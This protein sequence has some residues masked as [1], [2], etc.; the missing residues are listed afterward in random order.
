MSS[1]NSSESMIAERRL[2]PIYDL[3]D[4]NN[5][6]KAIQ[7]A[8]RVLKKSPDLDCA[9][10]LK[11][12]A[13]LRLGR[14]ADAEQLLETVAKRAPCDDPTL[15][16]MTICYRELRLPDKICNIYEEAVKK[17][18]TNEELLTH[19][20]MSYVRVYNYK[21]Q[22]HTAMSLYKLKSKN[23]YYFWAVMS[24]VMQAS[25]T[26]DNISKSITLPLA[27]RMVKKFID[28]NRID[29]EQEVQLYV[30]I[31][32]MQ[33]KYQEV[34]DLL[35]SPLGNM[36]QS[37]YTASQKKIDTLI[38][39]K[40]WDQVNLYLKQEL[41]VSDSWHNYVNYLTSVFRLVSTG[42]ANV[43]NDITNSANVPNDTTSSANLP[44]DDS[45]NVPNDVI[46]SADLSFE[47]CAQYLS[48]LEEKKVALSHKSR[49]VHL[50]RLEFY[51][52]LREHEKEIA[53]NT[54]STRSLPL[55]DSVLGASLVDLLLSYYKIFGHTPCC[56]KDLQKYLAHLSPEE[57]NVFSDALWKMNNIEGKEE[58]VPTDRKSMLQFISCLQFNSLTVEAKISLI[59][60]L[61]QTYYLCDA[62]T[63]DQA[64]AEI[65]A[66]DA[67]ILL[68]IYLLHDLYVLDSKYIHY[69]L[70][71]VHYVS[72]R[73]HYNFNLE[74]LALHYYHRIGECIVCVGL[75][76]YWISTTFSCTST[77]NHYNFNLELLALHY[78]H[79]L[80]Y[81]L[82]PLCVH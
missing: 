30:I 24:I 7:E 10:V 9:K 11:S 68:V 67:I 78:Y 61:T 52:K 3:L 1:K 13:L 29:A 51:V 75:Y 26:E 54:D 73:N 56:L 35:A 15:Q 82:H 55:A 79:P 4:F 66:N 16:A 37:Y 18:P 59:I 40:Q 42:S 36:L 25:K 27:E 12:L 57:V 71:Y 76:L 2:R 34:L 19:L 41:I 23:P 80:H 43:P 20:F 39:M 49:A 77:R 48:I 22:Q 65:K 72:T 6:K 28:E 21:K 44:N 33:Q 45:A 32:E 81:H 14:D 17:D 64:P 46:T 50:V 74:L 62:Y 47:S 58:Y 38:A 5:N 8:D 63:T 69:I 70:I 31:L 53:A 60:R